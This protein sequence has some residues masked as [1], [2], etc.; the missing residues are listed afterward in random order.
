MF[1]F[2]PCYDKIFLGDMMKKVLLIINPAAGK[3]RACKQ[4][5]DIIGVFNRADYDT[6]VYITAERGDATKAVLEYGKMVDLIVCCGGDGTF[7]ETITGMVRAALEIPMGYI[8]A[9][10][11]NDFAKTLS[12]SSNLVK[13]AKQ[14]VAG[15]QKV[16]DIGQFDDRFFSYV[17]SFGAFT[18]VSY[19]TPQNVKNMLG[20]LAYLLEGIKALSQIKGEHLKLVLDGEELEDNYIFGAVCNSTS[21][22]GVLTLKPSLVDISDGVFEVLLVR[23]PKNL[24]ELGDC[25]VSLTKQTYDSPLITLKKAKVVE[26]Y[27]DKEMNWSLDGEKAQGT[28]KIHIENLHKRISFIS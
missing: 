16:F 22:G 8:P 5:A 23:E 12:L 14:I 28:D 15:E 3:K 25:V 20:H 13:C 24:I 2:I 18:S 6:R 4:L 7:N 9:G 26:V 1:T 21:L 27:P 19:D 10:S 11:A 17:A